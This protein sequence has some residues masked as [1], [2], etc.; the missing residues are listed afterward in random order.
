[1]CSERVYQ[2]NDLGDALHDTQLTNASKLVGQFWW[3]AHH[4]ILAHRHNFH[5]VGEFTVEH[6]IVNVLG[7]DFL[8]DLVFA[9]HHRHKEVNHLAALTLICIEEINALMIG[10][11]AKG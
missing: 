1:M 4:T 6:T 2:V 10:F 9:G 11:D 3:Q 7:D 8:G 5:T